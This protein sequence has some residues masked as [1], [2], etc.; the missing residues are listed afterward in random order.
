MQQIYDRNL[1]QVSLIACTEGRHVIFIFR[2]Q[3]PIGRAQNVSHQ[4]IAI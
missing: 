3:N 2:Q 4:E 1:A